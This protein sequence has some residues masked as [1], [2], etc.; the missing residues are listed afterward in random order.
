MVSRGKGGGGGGGGV[1]GAVFV[2]YVPLASQNPC[3]IIA[4]FYGQL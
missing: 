3:P 4:I 1:L 2:G